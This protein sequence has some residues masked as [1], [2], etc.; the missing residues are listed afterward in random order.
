MRTYAM[1]KS[2]HLNDP[3]KPAERILVTQKTYPKRVGY[4]VVDSWETKNPPPED[5]A[6]LLD[7]RNRTGRNF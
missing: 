5:H 1:V 2:E 7:W 3:R 6:G 4:A